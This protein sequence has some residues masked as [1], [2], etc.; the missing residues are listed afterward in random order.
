MLSEVMTDYFGSDE[1]PIE[2]AKVYLQ[3]Q[4]IP[5]SPHRSTWLVH[6]SPER[7]YREFKFDNKKQVL[8]FI[9]EV[10]T[11]EKSCNHSGVQKIDDLTVSVEV[12][13]HDVNKITELDQ[14][15]AEQVGYIYKDVLNFGI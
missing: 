5:I 6:E 3:E 7:F 15:Y 10:L 11:Y 12:Y 9:A 14:E 8:D 4:C 1:R 13:T 2:K